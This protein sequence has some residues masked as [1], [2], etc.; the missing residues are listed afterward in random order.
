MA[1]VTVPGVD[2]SAI[3]FS[4]TNVFTTPQNQTLAQDIA[5]ALA[6]YFNGDPL[7]TQSYV[8]PPGTTSAAVPSDANQLLV[9]AASDN[10]TVFTPAGYTFVTDNTGGGN[11]T[12]A[13]AQNFIGGNGNLTVWDTVG[14]ASIGGGIDTIAAGNGND[15]FGLTAG[16]TYAVA[17]GNGTDTF[18]ANGS[19]TVSD[20]DGR[21]LIFAGSAS[22]TNV[23]SSYGTDTV[24]AGAGA[25]TVATHGADPLVFGGTGS[26]EVF[27]TTAT[28]ATVAG[29]SG[30]EIIFSAHS[31]VYFLGSS[32]SLFVGNTS[33][34]STIIGTTGT[35]TV[36]GGASSNELIFNNS[37]SLV[38]GAGSN[39]SATIIGG[40]SPSTLFGAAGSSINYFA[41]AGGALY[42]AGTGNETLN[43]ASSTA[44]ITVFGGHDSTAGNS[45]VGGA[46]NDALIAG[47]GSDTMTGGAGHNTFAFIN[48]A[49]GGHDFVT[50]YNANDVVGLFGYGAG[51]GAAA[52]AAAT[53]AGG[54]TTIALSDNTKIT[55]ENITTPSSIKI[56]ST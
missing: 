7:N 4:Y 47:S 26:L 36:F 22:G 21:N 2:G 43:A 40:A 28:N 12:V 15:L 27:G 18:F 8:P 41:T 45:L 54:A 9:T 25:N 48:G 17:A 38:F 42:S 16:S 55:F 24:V 39:D 23:V 53:V 32:T 56:F 44:N 37:S 34:D 35:E 3:S 6:A 11:F 29:G 10:G 14:A 19:G 1:A 51:A 50:D 13:G 33:S 20:G 31:G 52:L 30:S 46:G 49:A 5:N